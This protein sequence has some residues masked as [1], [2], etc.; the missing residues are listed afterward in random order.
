MADYRFERECRTPY[1]EVYTI[2]EEGE[3]IGRL[4]LH[5]TTS[6]VYATLCVPE[7]LT[8][9]AIQGLIEGIDHLDRQHQGEEFLAP[10]LLR[11][12]DYL[13]TAERPQYPQRP[14]VAVQFH[15]RFQ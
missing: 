5:F 12:R 1:S 14:F 2:M 15:A 4:D 11:R 7:R 10:V 6:V 9:E 13:G 8:T 3:R